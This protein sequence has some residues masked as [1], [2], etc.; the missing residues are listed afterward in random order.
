M[1]INFKRVMKSISLALVPVFFLGVL[2]GEASAKKVKGYF[3]LGK[4]AGRCSANINPNKKKQRTIVKCVLA[5]NSQT[6][7]VKAHRRITPKNKGKFT[8]RASR[9]RRTRNT[10]AFTVSVKSRK[11]KKKKKSARVVLR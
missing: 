3:S 1:N 5:G 7:A 9:V 6:F 11:G 4:K 2:T 10:L 8:L